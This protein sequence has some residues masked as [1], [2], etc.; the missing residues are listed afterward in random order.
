M[1]LQRIRFSTIL[2]PR[3]CVCVW[4]ECSRRCSKFRTKI[5][6]QTVTCLPNKDEDLN[7]DL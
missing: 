1:I 6:T 4:G 5:E 3:V 2:S 7:L